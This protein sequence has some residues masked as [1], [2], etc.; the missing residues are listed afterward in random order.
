M[1]ER[2]YHSLQKGT[3]LNGRYIIE[4]TKNPEVKLPGGITIKSTS[5]DLKKWAGDK[6]DY[7]KSG[8]SESYSYYEDN[9]RLMLGQKIRLIVILY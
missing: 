3:K 9:M 2:D 1:E 5:D 4:D 8:D 6:F 7:S